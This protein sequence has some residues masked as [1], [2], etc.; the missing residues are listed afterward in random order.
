MWRAF[1]PSLHKQTFLQLNRIPAL[2]DG[3]ANHAVILLDR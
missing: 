2:Q 1:D 3:G